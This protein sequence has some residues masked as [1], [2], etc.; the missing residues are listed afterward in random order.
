MTKLLWLALLPSSDDAFIPLH[1]LEWMSDEDE[2]PLLAAAHRQAVQEASW[3]HP[4]V[5]LEERAAK[6][7]ATAEARAEE[8][9][10]PEDEAAAH[11]DALE[12]QGY[13][14][15]VTAVRVALRE[16]RQ[17]DMAGAA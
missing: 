1:R 14:L 4:L 8:A 13:A 9:H 3:G 12:A 17:D 7:L 16:H 10:W 15:G 2:Y 5:A 6:L 11:R